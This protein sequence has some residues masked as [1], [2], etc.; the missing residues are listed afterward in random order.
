MSAMHNVESVCC[1]SGCLEADVCLEADEIREELVDLGDP[2][3][4]VK[5]GDREGGGRKGGNGG[6]GLD[7]DV[8]GEDMVLKL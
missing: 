5:C 1:N 3:A 7:D 2:I 8:E 4:S 6:L